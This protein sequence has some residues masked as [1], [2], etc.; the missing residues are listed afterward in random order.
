MKRI[1]EL[2][3]FIAFTLLLASVTTIAQTHY[4]VFVL[5]GQSNCNGNVESAAIPAAMNKTHTNIKC[6]V[7]ETVEDLQGNPPRANVRTWQ[8]LAPGWGYDWKLFSGPELS[9]AYTLSQL[10]PNDKIAIIKHNRPGQALYS[11]FRP[12]SSG[13]TTGQGFSMAGVSTRHYHYAAP[14][15]AQVSKLVLFIL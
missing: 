3:Y 5:S 8:A 13:G 15:I 4:K 9:M 7:G 12:P 14:L 11:Y 6:W 2:R 1:T 10:Y